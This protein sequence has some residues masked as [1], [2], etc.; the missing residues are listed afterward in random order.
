MPE[1]VVICFED[2]GEDVAVMVVEVDV[3]FDRLHRVEA[4][5]E[6]VAAAEAYSVGGR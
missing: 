6:D 1:S 5:T 3:E 2:T 4:V